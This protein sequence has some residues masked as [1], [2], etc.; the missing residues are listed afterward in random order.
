MCYLLV[1][2]PRRGWWVYFCSGFN[3]VR[4]NGTVFWF[5]LVWIS[6]LPWSV[7]V[8]LLILDKGFSEACENIHA[9]NTY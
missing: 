4:A 1:M 9:Y 7:H 3:N 5:C 8:A 6:F 2:E